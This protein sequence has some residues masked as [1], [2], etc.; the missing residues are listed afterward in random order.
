M[1][2]SKRWEVWNMV[3]KQESRFITVMRVLSMMS[4]V[5]CHYVVWFPKIS[6]IE[7]LFNIGVPLFF[8]ISG[9][10]YGKK[11]KEHP[12]KWLKNKIIT[13][14]I[15]LYIYYLIGAFVLLLFHRL[16][17]VDFLNTV[18]LCFHLQGVLGG[19]IG[20]LTVSHLW[21]ITFIFICYL[22]TPLLQRIDLPR[23]TFICVMSAVCVIEAALMLLL[24]TH[25]NLIW[26]P[27]VFSYIIAYYVSRHWPGK[28]SRRTMMILT[29]LMLFAV[30]A[31]FG[32]KA[33]IYETRLYDLVIRP[34]TQ[35]MI[36][37]WVFYMVFMLYDQL[38]N[39]GEKIYKICKAVEPYSYEVYI[40]HYCLIIGTLSVRSLTGNMIVNTI[41]LAAG[42]VLLSIALKLI[43]KPAVRLLVRTNNF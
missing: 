23:N 30:F 17:R 20:N 36:A 37:F 13:L 22:I 25:M 15:P 4:I 3:T 8:I 26:L 33:V 2:Q 43:S 19:G 31:R 29:L 38:G 42:I 18:K 34:Y 14:S 1:F 40:V 7:N 35:C 27:G 24:G 5:V 32:T 39:T 41:A 16:G 28:A 10:L 12:G 6:F 11:K 9:Y 21:F